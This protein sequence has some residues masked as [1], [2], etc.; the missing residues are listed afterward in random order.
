[1]NAM[2]LNRRQLLTAGAASAA[3][4]LLPSAWAQAAWPTKPL[5]LVVPFAPGGS[6][7]IVARAVASEVAKT[8]G[9]MKPGDVLLLENTRFYP[10]EEI[11]RAHV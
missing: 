7:E 5:R 4:G 2:P 10:G 1:M 9:V 3:T 8:I 11:G 6:S